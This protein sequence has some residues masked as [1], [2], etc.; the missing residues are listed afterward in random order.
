MNSKNLKCYNEYFV[1]PENN[2]YTVEQDEKVYTWMNT[3]LTEKSSLVFDNSNNVSAKTN[4]YQQVARYG[5]NEVNTPFKE[6]FYSN[7]NIVI[8]QRMLKN[9]V[10]KTS[11]YIIS[12]QDITEL[13]AVMSHVDGFY[14]CNPA[15]PKLFTEEVIRLNDI[16]VK[17]TVPVI[18]SEIKSH[19]AYLRDTK[20]HLH[21]F[22]S[23]PV[24]T[25]T[26]GTKIYDTLGAY[27]P[28]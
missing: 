2:S 28:K 5:K 17:E 18:I 15:D 19:L 8:L 26:T 20:Q 21:T 3:D 13:L 14:S 12:D 1:S 7:T 23:N 24:S 9:E 10:Y 27:Y 16:V 11:K 6:L 25:D 22:L 4:D